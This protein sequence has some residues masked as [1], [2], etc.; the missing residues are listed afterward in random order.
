MLSC[1]FLVAKPSQ[2]CH[3]IML[4]AG[5]DAGLPEDLEI[6]ALLAGLGERDFRIGAERHEFLFAV[7]FAGKAPLPGAIGPDSDKQIAAIG[8]ATRLACGLHA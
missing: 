7:E 2:A 4:A 8:A 1:E 5:R 6:T 3:R